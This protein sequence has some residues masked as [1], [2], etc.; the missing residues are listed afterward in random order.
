MRPIRLLEAKELLHYALK[1][2][3]ARALSAAEVRTRLL[4]KAASPADVDGVLAY[5][6]ENGLLNDERFAEHY[7]LARRDTQG[8]GKMRVLRDLR[9]RR[10]APPVAGSA[11][12]Q[13]FAGTNEEELV[14]SFLERKYR[15]TDLHDYLQDPKHLQS[16]FRKLRYAGFGM[17]TA[18]KVLKKYAQA[19][20]ALEENAELEEDSSS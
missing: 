4:R 6:R 13:V 9:Q 10:V 18:I 8:F 17:G 14:E 2:L 12:E 5:L 19:A 3:A 15:N 16:A 20:D 1:S 7:A 11:V